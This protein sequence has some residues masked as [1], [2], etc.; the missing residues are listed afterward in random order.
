MVKILINIVICLYFFASALGQQSWRLYGD[1]AQFESYG[2]IVNQYFNQ[3]AC[4][5]S[6]T[7]SNIPLVLINNAHDLLNI[8]GLRR[9][10][11]KHS[12]VQFELTAVDVTN[13]SGFYPAYLLNKPLVFDSRMSCSYI[14]GQGTYATSVLVNYPSVAASSY[15]FQATQT[16]DLIIVDLTL[17]RTN[18]SW[19]NAGYQCAPA[20]VNTNCPNATALKNTPV[21]QVTSYHGKRCI[22]ILR[23]ILL[24][25]SYR[26]F[27]TMLAT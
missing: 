3:T 4:A 16:T 20:W 24:H 5:V 19:W 26:L 2:S 10:Y 15:A 9:M 6:S 14:R 13:S 25:C 17:D 23:L 8:T 22:E 7:Y 18:S 11:P 27:I 21:C 12:L 1:I